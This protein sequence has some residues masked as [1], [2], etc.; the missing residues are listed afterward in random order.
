MASSAHDIPST[1]YRGQGLDPVTVIRTNK[2]DSSEPA[3]EVHDSAS[4]SS[5]LGILFPEAAGKEDKGTLP[6]GLNLGP[7]VIDCR[8]GQGGMGAVFKA[9]DERL[10]R[11][12]ALKVLSPTQVTDQ[13]SI[14]RFQN[15]AKA[16]ARLD[17]DNIAR[18]YSIGEDHGLH[19]IAFEYVEGQTI[20]EM[21]RR[22]GTIDP[23]ETINLL[24][25]I[26]I[27]LKHTAAA[28]VVHRDIKPSNLIMTSAG[29][30]KLVDWGLARK[31]RLDEQSLDLTVSGTTLGTFDYISPEQARDPR[32]VDVRSDIYSLGCTA[33]HMLT[34]TPPYAEGTVLQKLLDHQGKPSPDPRDK[35]PNVPRELSRIV[36][37]MMASDPDDRYWSPQALIEDLL[38][39]AAQSGLRAV[40]PDG[41][42][43]HA[44]TES[45]NGFIPQRV[46]WWWL[47][48]FAAACVLAIVFDRWA[49]ERSEIETPDLASQSL[50]TVGDD[51]APF[52]PNGLPPAEVMAPRSSTGAGNPILS[53]SDANS[54]ELQSP[55]EGLTADDVRKISPDFPVPITDQI[56]AGS[57]GFEGLWSHSNSGIDWD[58]FELP[59]EQLGV[60]RADI[61]DQ[62]ASTPVATSKTAKDSEM[63]AAA[64]TTEPVYRVIG[65]QGDVLSSAAD[66]ESALEKVPDGG[67]VEYL[68]VRGSITVQ[69]LRQIRVLDKAITIRGAADSSLVLKFNTSGF[70][71]SGRTRDFIAVNGGSL[72]LNNVHLQVESPEPLS[73]PW[74]LFVVEGA[75]KLRCR[76]STITIDSRNQAEASVVRMTRSAMQAIDAMNQDSS[77]GEPERRV[78]FDDCFIR[79]AADLIA[80]DASD[81]SLLEIS[82][83]LMT[84]QGALVRYVGDKN[85]RTSRDELT[86]QLSRVAGLVNYG[87]IRADL[88]M[89]MPR[90]PIDLHFRVEDSMLMSLM[91][92]PMIQLAGGLDHRTLTQLL[93][94]D[95]ENNLFGGWSSL[96]SIN[97]LGS[98]DQEMSS[99]SF[100]DWTQNGGQIR[101][102]SSRELPMTVVR[103]VPQISADQWTVE[104]FYEQLRNAL[105]QQSSTIDLTAYGPEPAG[106]PQVPLTPAQPTSATR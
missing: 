65:N 101:S 5:T 33:Y 106:L 51:V 19:Y 44:A 46:F 26:S 80:T 20:R 92:Q 100:S 4:K 36:K 32:S 61:S 82:R 45:R 12:V 71:A 58:Q 50:L 23:F 13:S 78:Q 6:E 105:S 83:C 54:L 21:I 47:G 25:Q 62:A 97:G 73:Q 76:Q 53:P 27:A 37:K 1:A 88:S 94:W 43:W 48:T 35:N 67:V 57:P 10:D 56:A 74:S 60:M 81:D 96:L 17:H 22:R 16:A 103:Q 31:E 75:A 3:P 15:E 30:A 28:G 89:T 49:L 72:T 91:E 68:G 104:R 85:T 24:L 64:A 66:L 38:A 99:L 93:W 34:G 42:T 84:L 70:S 8:I 41:L 95:G 59:E 63:P 102:I 79:G 69:E 9:R 39:M 18:I 87:L 29:R 40:H 55:M 98:I 52:F 7:Y 86:V 11:T 2:D 14:R 77:S 90:Q